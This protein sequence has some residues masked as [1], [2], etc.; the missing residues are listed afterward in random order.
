MMIFRHLLY[1]FA[2]SLTALIFSSL[3]S[4]EN[5]AAYKHPA[6]SKAPAKQIFELSKD[7]QQS[8]CLNAS[9]VAAYVVSATG[10][11]RGLLLRNVAPGFAANIGMQ[12]GDVLLSVNSRVIQTGKDADRVLTATEP[13]PTHVLFVH[14]TESGLQLYNAPVTVP[15]FAQL[16]NA[17]PM[18]EIA[19][20]AHRGG[21]KAANDPAATAACESYMVELVN[22]DRQKNGSPPIHVNSALAELAREKAD[23]MARRNYFSHVDPDGVGPQE[24]ANRAGIRCGT[25]ENLS[26]EQRP[27]SMREM[28]EL[29]E[30]SMISEPPNQKNHRSNILDPDHACVGIAVA[31]G[32][33]GAFYAVQEFAHTAP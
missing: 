5:A 8:A 16:S 3:W 31:R 1:V 10:T 19:E 4:G 15:R 13:G 7:E 25:Y 29:C 17:T 27:K 24:R 22:H 26:Y 12:A 23:D 18:P 14:P 20:G 9:G 11:N 2:W 6:Q 30:Q 32:K 21:E 33:D 28:V